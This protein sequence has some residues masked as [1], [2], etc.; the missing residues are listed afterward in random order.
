MSTLNRTRLEFVVSTFAPVLTTSVLSQNAFAAGVRRCDTH[1]RFSPD[2]KWVVI[3][4]PHT[5][6]RQ[7]HLIDIRNIVG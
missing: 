3:D 5:S 4:S 6:G 1:P 7:L 2:G